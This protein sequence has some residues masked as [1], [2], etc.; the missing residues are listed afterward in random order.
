MRNCSTASNTDYNDVACDE[1]FE[2]SLLL[3][4][5]II[6]LV[7]PLIMLCWVEPFWWKIK[8]FT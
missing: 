4:A 1:A 5:A 8:K 7:P 6:L 2:A 3:A